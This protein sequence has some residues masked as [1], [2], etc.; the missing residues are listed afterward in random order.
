MNKTIRVY[1]LAIKYWF[2]GD[3]WEAAL[4]YA[5]FIVYGVKKRDKGYE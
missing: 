2:I 3:D 4:S 5:K 1:Y